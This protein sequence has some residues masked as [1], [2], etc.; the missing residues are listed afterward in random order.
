MN[1]LF[2]ALWQGT[3]RKIWTYL[4]MSTL[5]IPFVFPFL[6]MIGSSLKKDIEVFASPP[7][8]L[9]ETFQ[10]HNYARVFEIQ[11]FA[12]QYWN[13]V[14][15]AVIVTLG[16]LLFSS[17]AGYAFARIQFR[18]RSLLFVL[19]LS[20]LMMPEEVTII[21]KFAFVQFL[22]LDNTHLPLIIFPIFGA[23]GVVATFMMRQHFLN[24]PLELEEAARLDGLNRWGIFWRIALPISTPVLS[25][26]TI[27]TF[28]YSWNAFLEPLVYLEEVRLFTLPLA[29]R[30][31][32]DEFGIPIWEVQLAATTLSVLPILLFYLAAQRLI[33]ESFATSGVKG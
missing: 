29:L 28:L 17:L 18:G 16:T 22:G 30:G 25:A 5:A 1:T 15:I 26:V 31:F 24:M 10:W 32:T 19:L 4:V 21:P 2:R 6:W 11:P 27:I 3:P 7:T 13:S 12:Q 14:Y 33:V 23:H 9:P 8:L 20:G